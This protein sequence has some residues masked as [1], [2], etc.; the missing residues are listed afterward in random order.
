MQQIPKIII[1]ASGGGSNAKAIYNYANT[2][3]TFGV[4]AIITN[5]ET[6]G[7]ISFANE[8]NIPVHIITTSDLETPLFL[9][10]LQSY[11]PELL[12]LAGFLK[13]I[14]VNLID[15]FPNRIINIHPSLL[16]KY[17][18]HGMYGSRVHE[19]VVAA[20]EVES[21]ITIHYVNQAYDEGAYIKQ[22]NITIGST[23]TADIVAE[24]VLAIEHE[25]YPKVIEELLMR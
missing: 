14:S 21:G 8:K 20:K 5:K 1:F 4:A 7:I 24:K 17:G 15:A 12:I 23:D 18:G 16:P 10:T 25:W 13:K 11:E 3:N 22:V 6:A 19:A 9:Q 2:Q